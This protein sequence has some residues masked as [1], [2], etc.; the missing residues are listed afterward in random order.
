MTSVDSPVLLLAEIAN[1]APGQNEFTIS[2]VFEIKS[3]T[4]EITFDFRLVNNGA[5]SSNW[6]IDQASLAK[7]GTVPDWLQI[8]TSSGTITPN[9]FGQ[10]QINI[11]EAWLTDRGVPIPRRSHD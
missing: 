4:D 6:E 7:F 10:Q 8:G 3:T 5:V 2:K 1:G 11:V 9:D